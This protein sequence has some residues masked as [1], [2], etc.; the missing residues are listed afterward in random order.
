LNLIDAVRLALEARVVDAG[1]LQALAERCDAVGEGDAA[2]L[3]RGFAALAETDPF[4]P[5]GGSR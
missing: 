2:E 5:T 4:T 3:A 1:E